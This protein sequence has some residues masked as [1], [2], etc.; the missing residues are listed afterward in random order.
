MDIETIKKNMQEVNEKVATLTKSLRRYKTLQQK[1]KMAL[2]L[3]SMNKP[4]TYNTKSKKE[5]NNIT[6]GN[7]HN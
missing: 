4:K 2:S 3:L 5:D 7:T 1:Q 6:D